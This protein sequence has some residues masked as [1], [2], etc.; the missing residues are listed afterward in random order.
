[1]K[2]SNLSSSFD[3]P[4]EVEFEIEE[5]EEKEEKL[6]I[7]SKIIKA[8]KFIDDSELEEAL[9]TIDLEESIQTK[10]HCKKLNP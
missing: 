1:M 6:K 4:E 10:I 5:K 8:S 7:F 2:L 3:F 9:E